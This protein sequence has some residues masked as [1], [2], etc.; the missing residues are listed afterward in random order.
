MELGNVC[1]GNIIVPWN[2]KGAI[3]NDTGFLGILWNL[4]IANLYDTMLHWTFMDFSMKI[5]GNPE[6]PYQI[7][8]R[9]TAFRAIRMTSFQITQ[10]SVEF[11]GAMVASFQKSHGSMEFHGIFNEISWNYE[12]I[13]LSYYSEFQ[14]TDCKI[15]F[16]ISYS[17]KA[18]V[19]SKQFNGTYR[20][21]SYFPYKVHIVT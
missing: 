7:S 13:K 12:V 18:A 19:I 15:Y 8:Q 17:N 20:L 10:S 5:L 4:V 1:F 21:C 6:S 3:S 11:H 14:A 16:A 2:Y 9:S